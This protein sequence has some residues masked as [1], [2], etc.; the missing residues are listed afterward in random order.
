MRWA[1]EVDAMGA[2]EREDESW[3]MVSND[4]FSASSDVSSEMAFDFIC[5]E[6]ETRI[7]LS[8]CDEGSDRSC[9][10]VTRTSSPFESFRW[11]RSIDDDD[12]RP[13]IDVLRPAL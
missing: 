7:M 3:E 13:T 5:D 2:R 1:V 12:C 11:L 4:D 6:R 9:Q 8:S 10:R